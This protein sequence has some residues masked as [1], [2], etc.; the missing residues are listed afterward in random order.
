MQLFGTGIMAARHV[1]GII[2]LIPENRREFK[3][4]VSFYLGKFGFNLFFYEL[5]NF[6][7]ILF[8]CTCREKGLVNK[9]VRVFYPL[10]LRGLLL[11]LYLCWFRLEKAQ[12]NCEVGRISSCSFLFFPCGTV[13]LLDRGI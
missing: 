3:T 13:V 6:K 9:A 1:L 2:F 4:F 10:Y 11:G 5:R 8:L 12:S 7:L